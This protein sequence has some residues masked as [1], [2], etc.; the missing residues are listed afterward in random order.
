MRLT[1]PVELFVTFYGATLFV[2]LLIALI[3]IGLAALD[4]ACT[5]RSGAG[6]RHW[7]R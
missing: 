7:R 4:G 1:Q 6:A 2:K 5:A 3:A